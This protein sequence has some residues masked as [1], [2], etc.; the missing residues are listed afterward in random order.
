MKKLLLTGSS[1]LVGSR[2]VEL[3][4]DKYELITPDEEEL[5]LL[6]KDSISSYLKNN[7]P[8]VVL[9]LAAFTDVNAAEEQTGD[10]SG[11]CWRLNVDGVKLLME[12]LPKKTRL[13]Q[14][15]T[16][17]VFSGDKQD[18]GPYSEDHPLPSDSKK[19]TWYGWTKNR[20]EKLA[21]D[22]GH[23]VLRIIYPV[24]LHFEDKADYLR[25]ILNKYSQG[26]LS[27][28]FS[29]QVITLTYIDHLASV[30]SAIVDKN[31]SGIFHASSSN[32]TSPFELFK[33]TL[34]KLG[35][36]SSTIKQSS[37]K[38][39]LKTLDNPYRYPLFGGLKTEKSAQVTGVKYFTWQE[40]I[41]ELISQGLSL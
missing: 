30:V 36:D 2:L 14:V 25:S 26:N 10:K 18:P 13:I 19:L 35:Q 32:S 29:D 33:Y 12:S 38:D 4:A 15:S 20:G 9:N 11:L 3:L 5:N 7:Q 41:D 31:L 39:Y 28:L 8:D 6:D 22:A 16:D 1:G 27:P 17:M 40:I 34:E 23:S 24:R 37:L 21:F